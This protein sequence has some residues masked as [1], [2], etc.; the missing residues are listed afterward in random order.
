VAH[1][2]NRAVL[3]VTDRI[4]PALRRRE[5]CLLLAGIPSVVESERRPSG[6]YY[7][8]RVADAD[9]VPAH[10]ALAMGGCARPP[11]LRESAPPPLIDGLGDVAGMLRDEAG[12]AAARLFAAV[13]AAAPLLLA[14]LLDSGA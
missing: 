6:I 2:D 5:R 14:A 4:G 10:L 8:L 1:G 12:I 9:A 11:R 3:F 13:R 7:K